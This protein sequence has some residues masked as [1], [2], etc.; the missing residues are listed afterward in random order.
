L[1]NV[2]G[3]TQM[4]YCLKLHIGQEK[5][6][7]KALLSFRSNSGLPE[8]VTILRYITLPHLLTIMNHN[9]EENVAKYKTIM[10]RFL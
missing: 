5:R 7:G 1:L 4:F 3:N 9:V 2:L 10:L 6:K 8:R